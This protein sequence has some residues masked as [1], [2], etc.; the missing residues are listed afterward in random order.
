MAGRMWTCRSDLRGL[1]AGVLVYVVGPRQVLSSC[2][3]PRGPE[4][5][6]CFRLHHS[7]QLAKDFHNIFGVRLCASVI[8]YVLFG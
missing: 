5:F 3:P 4:G 2:L 8:R 1:T 6:P 7:R